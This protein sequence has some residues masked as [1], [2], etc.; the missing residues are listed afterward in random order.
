MTYKHLR[1]FGRAGFFVF[2]QN[3]Y[4]G[5]GKCALCKHA[6]QQVGQFKRDKKRIC[7]HACTKRTGDN[8]IAHKA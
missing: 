3:W 8:R 5:L 2:C 6:P 7:R 4:E 1:G